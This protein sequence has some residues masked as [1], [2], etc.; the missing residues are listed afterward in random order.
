MNIIKKI[1]IIVLIFIVILSNVNSFS[2]I[3]IKTTKIIPN[4]T[5]QT[6]VNIYEGDCWEGYTLL[7]I[8]SFSFTDYDAYTLLIDM[9][10]TEINRWDV[11]PYPAIMLLGGSIIG[12]T[13]DFYKLSDLQ[14]LIQL[15]WN[16]SIEWSYYNWNDTE[17]HTKNARQHHDFQREGNPVGYYAPDQEFKQFGKTLILAHNLTHNKSICNKKLID[18]IIYEVNWD[19]TLSDFK[20]F[21]S[22][23]YKELGFDLKSRIGIRLNPGGP[24]LLLFCLPGDWL[25][26]NTISVVG[27]NRWYDKD[28]VKYFHFHPDNIMI[29]SRHANFIAIISKET[30]GIVWRVGPDFDTFLLEKNA[31]LGQIIGPH[32]AHMIPKGLPGAGNIL[33]FDNGGIAGY[34]LFG[35]PSKCRLYSRVIEFNP[36]T[37]E[38]VWEYSHKEGLFPLPRYGKNHRFFSPIYGSA[39]RLPNGNTLITEG[40]EG[41]V[42]E[43]TTDDEVVWDYITRDLRLNVYRAYRIPPEWVPNNPSNYAFWEQLT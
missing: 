36:E 27:Q 11:V 14:K 33:V 42:F 40:S 5:N 31:K 35:G 24:G 34:G 39:Q 10:G 28:P 38:I 20:W 7:C 41:H 21:A 13:G 22:D 3:R 43:V 19:G 12:G 6:G 1:V 30:G 26:I 4:P 2:A 25:H 23:H 18:D 37:L 16:G 9:N 17:T 15:S 8:I 29:T 32:Y